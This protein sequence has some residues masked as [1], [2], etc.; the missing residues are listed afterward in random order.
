MIVSGPRVIQPLLSSSFPKGPGRL[1]RSLQK[2]V[3]SSFE[4]L[5]RQSVSETDRKRERE[6]EREGGRPVPQ[7]VQ[8]SIA[9]CIGVSVQMRIASV[10]AL[11]DLTTFR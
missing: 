4:K 9:S 3:I 2:T 5:Y 8:Y 11:T 6:R 1:R 7:Q 10:R